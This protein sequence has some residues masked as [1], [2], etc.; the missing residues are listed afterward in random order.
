MR[1]GDYIQSRWLKPEDT[2]LQMG[3]GKIVTIES[4]AEEDL[5]LP[6][7]QQDYKP[8]VKFAEFDKELILNKT[9]IR[10]LIEALGEDTD[11]M[12]G[13]QIRLLVASAFNP[14]M[15]RQEEVLRLGPVERTARTGQRAGT[16]TNTGTGARPGTAPATTHTTRPAPATPANDDHDPFAEE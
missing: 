9:N 7:G 4:F 16:V 5:K 10:A 2:D 14:Q 3:E 15:Q 8:V 6:N 11:T 12:I 1:L 13:K